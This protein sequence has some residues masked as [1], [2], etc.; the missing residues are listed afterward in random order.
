MKPLKMTKGALELL[1]KKFC[2]QDGRIAFKT[3]HT[4]SGK[5]AE[6]DRL[7]RLAL[8]VK[9]TPPTWR[10]RF[11]YAITQA[12]ETVA[13]ENPAEIKAGPARTVPAEKPLPT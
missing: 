8:V 2:G 6:W 12:G 1:R 7:E 10:P 13:L 3:V 4:S 11:S 5:P 9:T